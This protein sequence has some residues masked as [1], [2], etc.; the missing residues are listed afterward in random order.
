MFSGREDKN[1]NKSQQ[2]RT[3]RPNFNVNNLD[4]DNLVNQEILEQ[5]RKRVGDGKQQY[6]N[7]KL[8]NVAGQSQLTD[9]LRQSAI[10]VQTNIPKN[11]QS[12]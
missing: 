6:T 11:Q 2:I 9:K 7:E 12:A 3:Q 10:S 1:G 5:E 8:R 4:V